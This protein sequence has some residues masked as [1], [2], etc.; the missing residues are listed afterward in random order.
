MQ[1]HHLAIALLALLATR[2]EGAP[3]PAADA[4]I[5]QDV[6]DAVADVPADRPSLL[7]P[8]S[9]LDP[10]LFDCRAQ[11]VPARAS[12]VPFSCGTDRACR[13]PQVMGHRGA[14]GEGGY[15]AP[16]D[17]LAAY[18]AAIALGIEYVETDPRPTADGVIVNMHDTTVDRTTD[19]T[20]T[21]SEMTF[22]A[23]RALHLRADRFAGEFGCERVPTLREI[24]ELCRGR[25]TV[26]V[27]ANKTDRVDLLVQAIREANA[28]DSVV[29]STSDIEK[30]RRALAMEPGIRAHIRP[31]SVA[32]ITEQLDA[33]APVVPALVEL[34]RNDVR[35]GAPIV[36]ARGTRVAVDIFAEDVVVGLR[37]DIAYYLTPFDDGADVVQSDRPALVLDALRAAG[38]R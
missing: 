11:A 21:V 15:I 25:A 22:A 26:V 38:R 23:V 4:A 13:T 36:H 19:G 1:H 35:A 32:E 5:A 3:P 18:R 8:T 7:R 17:S 24:L 28:V 29:F 10:R 16:E 20:G 33:L 9:P 31:R 30:V 2:C 34:Q 14:G 12:A 37:G 6:P 27:D